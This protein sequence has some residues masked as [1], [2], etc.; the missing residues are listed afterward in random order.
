MILSAL[1]GSFGMMSAMIIDADSG[2]H[3]MAAGDVRVRI[4]PRRGGTITS[5]VVGG[6]ELLAQGDGYGC[7]PMAPWCGRIGNGQLTVGAETHQLPLNADPH[8]IHGTVRDG[9]WD[10]VDASDTHMT[11]RQALAPPWPF[12]G[13]VIQSFRLTED[14]LDLSMAVAAESDP[15]PAQV[16]W[17]P[18]F[19]RHLSDDTEPVRIDFAPDWQ[20]LRGPDY[21]PS[22]ARIAPEPGPWDDCFGMVDGV[23]VALTWPGVLRL[24]V[25]SPERWVVVYDM[26]DDAVCVEPQSGPPDGVNTMPRLV[27]PESPLT[28]SCRWTW[29]RL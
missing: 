11:L 19:K 8:A 9:E 14:V 1:P 22:G 5:L 16:G 13:R 7:F 3:E 26:E 21:L 18:W 6:T 27:T 28:A 25:S 10:V 20:E 24:E 29:T 4:S 17:H 12:T 15:F 23:R 2:D